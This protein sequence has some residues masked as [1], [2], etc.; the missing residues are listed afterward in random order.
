MSD[1]LQAMRERG[2]SIALDDFGT[3]F[4]SLAHL[5][6]APIDYIKLDRSFIA[7]LGHRADSA[8]I[9]RSIVDLGHSLGMRIV[10]EGIETNDQADFLRA[11]GC[12]EVQGFLF[13]RPM[14]H[15]SARLS[16]IQQ[17]EHLALPSLQA[18]G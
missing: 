11:I 10:A 9:V 12:D 16:L 7:G 4:A 2:I 5:R 18:T 13:G 14:P 17:A 3:G 15:D 8:I 1:A 6:D